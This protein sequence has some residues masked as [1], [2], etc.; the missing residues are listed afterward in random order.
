MKKTLTLVTLLAAGTS[1]AAGIAIDTQGGRATGMGSTGVA[2]S[3]DASSIYFNAAG[4]LGVNR[5]DAQLG[6]SLILGTLN[7]TPE[8]GSEQTQNPLSPPPHAYFVY[9]FSPQVA[10]GVGV[11]VPYGAVSFWPD[12]FTGRFIAKSSRVT[13]ADINPTVAF[14]P[15]DW[16]R[17]GAGV[18]L[19]YGSLNIT[20][21]LPFPGGLPEGT[22]ELTGTDWGFGYN[23]GVQADVV[24]RLLTVGAHYRSE[25][26]MTLAGDADFQDVPA[27]AV[28]LT[29]PDQEFE[30][31]LTLPA[32]VGLGVAITPMEKLTLAVDANWVQW[33]SL[34][35]LLFEFQTTSALNQPAVKDW[36]SRVN[37]RVGGEYK[38]TDALAVRAG[39]VYDPAAT[40]EET[41]GPDLPDFDRLKFSLGAG[42]A[43][44]AFRADLGYQLV[45]IRDQ[46]ST[47]PALPG[48]YNGMAHI[49]GLTLG[50]SQ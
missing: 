38:A 43:F 24:P 30:L 44:S 46:R 22:L 34:Q 48:T 27:P 31:D 36:H 14:A 42:Y 15:L 19:V 28:P 6:D 9:K 12:D 1:Q 18:Q 13:S 25:V 2:S 33:S 11:F 41:L 29:P 26:N 21:R 23:V 37:V 40:P 4:I 32:S 5:L 50:Y 47:L 20:R 3:K 39:F 17:L 35:Q 8:G 49:L 45:L 16:L 7:F 10:A